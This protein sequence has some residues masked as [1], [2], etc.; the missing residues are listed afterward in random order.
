M[1]GGNFEIVENE[2]YRKFLHHVQHRDSRTALITVSNHRSVFDDPG[3]L[4]CLLPLPI[5][6]ISRNIRW[7]IC[8]EEVCF[9][10]N[11]LLESFFTAGKTI[12]IFRGGGVNQQHLLDYARQ[13]AD[14]EWLHI[15]PEGAVT[16]LSE[17]GGRMSYQRDALGCLKWG[18]AKLIAHAPVKPIMVPYFHTGMDGVM[19]MDHDRKLLTNFPQLNQSISVVFGEELKFDDLIE[20]H[21]RNYG[22]LW[23]YSTA[24]NVKFSG[25]GAEKGRWISEPSDFLLYNKITDRIELALNELNNVPLR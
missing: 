4:S 14:G 24:S 5:A 23:K 22:P 11:A 8:A 10:N 7:N 2:N 1:V 13:A 17:L 3:L 21:E 12:P 6:L 15:F 16:Q 19:P 18:V 25:S 20:E 9:Q